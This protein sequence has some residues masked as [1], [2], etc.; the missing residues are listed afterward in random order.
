MASTHSTNI[1]FSYHEFLK[2]LGMKIT[3]QTRC[4]GISGDLCPNSLSKRVS[5]GGRLLRA[6]FHRALKTFEEGAGTASA[7]QLIY[8][9]TVPKGKHFLIIT[10]HKV[11]HLRSSV[12]RPSNKQH[13]EKCG[14]ILV[15][16][17]RCAG[18][19]WEV[20]PMPPLLQAEEASGPQTLLTEWMF[21]SQHPGGLCWASCILLMLDQRLWKSNFPWLQKGWSCTTHCVNIFGLCSYLFIPRS[22]FRVK[23]TDC[24]FLLSKSWKKIGS[25]K[26]DSKVHA[27]RTSAFKADN[28]MIS[29]VQVFSVFLQYLFHNH[30]YMQNLHS[31]DLHDVFFRPSKLSV[32]INSIIHSFL[33]WQ[34]NKTAH[35]APCLPLK[36]KPHIPLCGESNH[37]KVYAISKCQ[38]L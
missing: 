27:S 25:Q 31:S 17:P 19:C 8:S 29:F 9:L 20:P 38:I 1:S 37:C 7:A 5:F 21:Q 16:S 33:H 23:D 3:G 36:A 22:Y 11:F 6:L 26:R 35:F 30:K 24:A 13:S 14:S 12:S 10:N 34:L 15:I 28:R 2:H 32:G 18:G 4:E